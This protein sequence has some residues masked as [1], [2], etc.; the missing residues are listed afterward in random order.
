MTTALDLP[1]LH[2]VFAPPVHFQRSINVRYDLGVAEYIAAYV[3]TPHAAAA[4]ADLLSA[5]EP[6]MRQRAHV[7]IG[8]YGSGKSLFA[9]AL[10]ALLSGAE[11][12]ATVSAL[13][14]MQRRLSLVS[15]EVAHVVSTYRAAGTHLLPVVLSGEEGNLAVALARALQRALERAEIVGLYPPTTFQAALE[16]MDRW[17]VAHP[18]AYGRLLEAIKGRR[19]LTLA[20]LQKGLSAFSAESLDQFK[21]FYAHVTA[22]ATFAPHPEHQIADALSATAI[23]LRPYGYDGVVI[24][25]DEFG[26][27]LDAHA[28]QP[29]GAN[30][31][32]LQD[33]AERA[34]RSDDGQLHLVLITHK[35][36]RQYAAGL[37][38]EMQREWAR[39]EQR[40]QSLDLSGDP[41]VAY[42]LIASALEPIDGVAWQHLQD[43][44]TQAF[45]ALVTETMQSSLFGGLDRE[46]LR[47]LVVE[48][49]YP[50]HPA[51]AYC[52]PRLSERVAQNERTLFTFLSS[53]D[54]SALPVILADMEGGGDELPLV[55][56]DRLYDYFA[57]A[58]KADTGPGGAH[59]TWLSAEAALR[60]FGDDVDACAAVKALAVF[61]VVGGQSFPSMELLSF[62]LGTAAEPVLDRLKARKAVI[63][64]RTEGYWQFVEGSDLDIEHEIADRIGKIALTPL[65]ARQLVERAAPVRHQ[66]AR[67][68]NDKYAMTRFFHS[69]YRTP[70][71][72]STVGQEWEGLLRQLDYA[73]GLLVYVLATNDHE[74]AQ[75]RAALARQTH[76]RVVFLMASAPVAI[77]EPLRE[78]LALDDLDGDPALKDVDER[79]GK[80]LSYFKEEATI[81]LERALT[82]LVDPRRG[83]RLWIGGV[84]YPEPIVSPGM[85]S[86]ALS[87]VLE[88]S[89]D[90]TPVISN[91]GLNRRSPT[92]QQ[93]RAA[94]KVINGF[95]CEPLLPNLGLTGYGPDVA[96][97][98]TVL[99]NTGILGDATGADPSLG[100]PATESRMTAVWEA[101]EA[102]IAEAE[103]RN[104]SFEK[105]MDLLQSPPY[106]LRRGVL[107]ILLAVC[108][109][110]YLDR[111]TVAH[112]NDIVSPL[113]GSTF[114]TICAHPDQY[115]LRLEPLDA[116]RDT[117]LRCIEE[118]V[119]G[120]VQPEER[121]NQPLRY[122]GLGLLRWLQ[123][124]PPYARGT[125]Q[126]SPEAVRFR[127]SIQL[128][129]TQPAQSL[130][131][132]LPDVLLADADVGDIETS[133][134]VALT[135]LITELE[136]AYNNLVVRTGETV[137]A[138]FGGQGG[139]AEARAA[140]LV[141]LHTTG[142]RAGTQ[143]STHLFGDVF[144]DALVAVVAADAPPDEEFV[145]YLGRRM[146]GLPLRDWGDH[147]EA[148]FEERLVAARD[149]IVTELTERQVNADDM[150]DG[151]VHLP[152]GESVQFQFKQ[153][154][155]SVHA[156]NLLTNLKN[157]IEITGR[158]LSVDE[159][160]CIGLE[161]LRHVLERR[162]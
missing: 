64:R 37:S 2:D 147:T 123:Q 31:Q 150:F 79:I 11:E 110:R 24:V 130:L 57:A 90:R 152:G 59:G 62:A 142:D 95:L 83:G 25:H 68:Y 137:V 145:E 61:L 139:S 112:G 36:L 9:V 126:L 113:V 140:L 46:E 94:E 26:R 89:F 21:D 77:S 32:L 104:V 60:K 101:M 81:R 100:A 82:P 47:R 10:A 15:P 129:T 156:K 102:A 115:T 114:T 85:L 146:I 74:V 128:A 67:R 20:R 78:L 38:D 8:A 98:R 76:P 19:G 23:A 92:S 84:A 99:I 116:R 160:R 43:H 18:D 44:H 133:V 144:A 136:A 108:L 86:R 54:D 49:A 16:T 7:L 34:N 3:P 161:V 69:M 134:R 40:F 50:L 14:T 75:A 30:A 162:G 93:T 135:R 28:G 1:R 127:R 4:L 48:G 148:Q 106:G 58:M 124:L 6:G 151:I 41:D 55:H 63:Y 96:V 121:R 80:E 125:R 143:V 109:R 107:P 119:K 70:A 12:E 5:S 120:F 22:G 71:E 27:F 29:F 66:P 141:W 103:E 122:L 117:I 65:Q 39:I 87:E 51:T 105:I 155:L 53:G 13:E 157:T 149:R 154:E 56:V 159:R 88:R 118:R 131:I 17:Q 35:G 153:A 97:M 111:A 45:N 42:R 138:T 158:A 52:L 33:L 91:E 132:D 72:L 73:D